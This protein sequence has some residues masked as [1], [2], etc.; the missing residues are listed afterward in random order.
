MRTNKLYIALAAFVFLLPF[1]CQDDD[2]I[3]EPDFETAVHG[4]A[5]LSQGSAANF[6]FGD[7]SVNLSVDLQWISIDSENTVNKIEIYVFFNESYVDLE[8]N[9]TTARHGGT[10]GKLLLSL[11]GSE[12]PGN[13]TNT[14]FSLTQDAIYELYKDARFDYGNGEVPVWGNPDKPRRNDSNFKFID[15]DSFSIRWILYTADGRKFDT[16]N[17]S[18][19]LEFPGANCSLAWG[20]I[21]ESDIGGSYTMVSNGTEYYGSAFSYTFTETFEPTG[22]EGKYRI[23]DLSGGMEP[24]IWGNPD[25][26]AVVIDEC[27]AIKLDLTQFSYLYG[28]SILD[29]SNINPE[30]GVIT[31]IWENIYGENG[32][33][34]YTPN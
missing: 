30:T 1:S 5:Q 17:D 33:N 25:V 21:C 19:C 10:N 9:P 24:N 15:G 7:P 29:G 3:P 20:I 4:F 26:E 32:V 6:K 12:V 13:R 14:T 31:I 11:E 23:K 22:V 2:L 34:V 18:V 28:Y 8:G 16:W 27:G